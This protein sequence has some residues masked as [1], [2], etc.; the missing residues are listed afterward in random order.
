MLCRICKS[1]GRR[2]KAVIYIRHHKL[3]LCKDHFIEWFEKQT[4]KAIKEFKMFKK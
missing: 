2:T 1:K 4:A 3:A